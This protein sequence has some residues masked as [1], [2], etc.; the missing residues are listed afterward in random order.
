[1]LCC[2]YAHENNNKFYFLI[3]SHRAAYIHE[4]GQVF[5]VLRHLGRKNHVNDILSQYLVRISLQVLRQ[6]FHT[7]LDY[8]QR[9]RFT[10]I[11]VIRDT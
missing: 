1:M 10:A 6:A 5:K 11:R 2:F 7:Y 3:L 4:L 9:A 8:I